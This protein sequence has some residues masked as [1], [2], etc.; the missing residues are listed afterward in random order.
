MNSPSLSGG[1]QGIILTVLYDV[2][3]KHDTATSRTQAITLASLRDDPFQQWAAEDDSMRRSRSNPT[4]SRDRITISVPTGV[5]TWN[6]VIA[7]D[8]DFD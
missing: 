3:C 2:H 1:C 8:S 7:P 4:T 6:P 5:V